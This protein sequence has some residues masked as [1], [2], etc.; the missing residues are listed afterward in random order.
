ME[1]E[2]LIKIK[3]EM[4]NQFEK[5]MEISKKMDEGFRRILIKGG[6]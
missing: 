5:V 3:R 4:D 6:E 1:I 2:D